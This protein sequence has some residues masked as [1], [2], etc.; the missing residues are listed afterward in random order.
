MNIQVIKTVNVFAENV[1]DFVFPLTNSPVFTPIPFHF[2]LCGYMDSWKPGVTS[3]PKTTLRVTFFSFLLT[4]VEVYDAQLSKMT[5]YIKNSD[6]ENYEPLFDYVIELLPS[7]CKLSVNL[8]R[9]IQ[10]LLPVTP[11]EHSAFLHTPF[12]NMWA[13]TPD[14]LPG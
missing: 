7:D 12:R 6:D 13:R 10:G 8:Q 11:A 3:I 9:M 14:A 2:S 1:L 5:L 4:E